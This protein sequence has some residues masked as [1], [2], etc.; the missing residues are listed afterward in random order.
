MEWFAWLGDGISDAAQRHLRKMLPLPS[1]AS[2]GMMGPDT[3]RSASSTGA[4]AALWDSKTLARVKDPTEASAPCARAVLAP[5][6]SA[7]PSCDSGTNP[8]GAV[9]RPWTRSASTSTHTCPHVCTQQLST[10]PSLRRLLR[11]RRS[12]VPSSEHPSLPSGSSTEAG[13]RWSRAGG[14]AC[15]TALAVLPRLGNRRNPK[16]NRRNPKSCSRG[17]EPPQRHSSDRGWEEPA[18]LLPSA[19]REPARN[20]C[21]P[22]SKKIPRRGWLT[23]WR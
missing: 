3:R 19:E 22:E 13:K 8:W 9:A 21:E 11:P 23:C 4:R 2:P 7:A 12:L 1:C 20:T 10:F 16:R 14:S 6:P 5:S 17:A 18:R 15:R